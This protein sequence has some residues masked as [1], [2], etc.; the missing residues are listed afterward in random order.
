ML[1]IYDTLRAKKIS[2]RPLEDRVVKMYT[3]GPTVYDYAHIGNFRAFVV[4]DIVR[5]YLEFRDYT[6]RSVRNITDV[7]HL[8]ENDLTRG[9]DKV[10]ETALREKKNPARVATFYTEVF[11]RD[12][13]KL[14]ILRP[15][16]EPR[17]TQYIRQ[18]ITSVQDL[19]RRGY[20][21][22]AHGWVFFSVK[23]F[24]G[25]GRLSKNT[26]AQL[27][28]GDRLEVHPDKR[29]P[30]D[31]ALWRKAPPGYL[32]K[33]PSPW[34]EGYP[35]WH[36]EC[37]TMAIKILG[38]MLDIHMGGEDNIFPHHEDE[39]TQSE[40]MTGRPFVRFWMHPRFLLINRQKISKSLKNYYTLSDI[41][42]RGFHPLDFRMFVLLTHYRKQA[43]FTFEGLSAAAEARN[44]IQNFSDTIATPA[45]M[46][47]KHRGLKTMIVRA[48]RG[49]NAAL[50]D[51]FNTPRALAVLLRFIKALNPAVIQNAIGSAD[52]RTIR[53]FLRTIDTIFGILGQKTEPIPS[54]VQRLVDERE[55]TRK[56]KN[57]KA[58]DALRKRIEK[59]G[60]RVEDTHSGSRVEKIRNSR[61]NFPAA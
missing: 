31:F 56:A 47:E 49:I 51:D 7:G 33:W 36:I 38:P 60:Y 5:R 3:C 59:L 25:Y 24:P 50:D 17:A 12:A 54:R 2:F 23:S 14:N 19:I 43:N 30:A 39:R 26:I 4:S 41:E 48:R 34:G 11:E 8:S 55:N 6:V 53:A 27:R 32:M 29:H 40:S 22:E 16:S 1:K 52:A 35:G 15:M 46:A 45:R 21:Y 57:W 42:H 18:M 61:R 37:S 20:A 28:A 13:T 58:A 9:R 10:I 44:R